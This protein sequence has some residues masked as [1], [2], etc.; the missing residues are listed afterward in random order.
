MTRVPKFK[1]WHTQRKVMFDVQCMIWNEDQTTLKSIYDMAGGEYD[2][3]YCELLEWTRFK[4]KDGVDI[5]FGSIVLINGKNCIVD[6][7]DE[8][9]LWC[10][11][12]EVDGKIYNEMIG[13]HMKNIVVVGHIYEVVNKVQDD[14]Q[15]EDSEPTTE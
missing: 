6:W 11:G 4:D 14:E 8:E 1:A 3:R 5:Y 13:P 7:D 10:C 15:T 9:G 2:P 12:V